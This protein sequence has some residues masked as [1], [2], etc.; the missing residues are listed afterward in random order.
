M[1]SVTRAFGPPAGM[2][3]R[4]PVMLS[5]AKHLLFLSGKQT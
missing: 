4:V 5:E 2:E 1:L 3:V